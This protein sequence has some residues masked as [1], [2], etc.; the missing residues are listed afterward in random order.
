MDV[1]ASV[2]A[3]GRRLLGSLLSIS[4]LR[5]ASL[6]FIQLLGRPSLIPNLQFHKPHPELTSPTPFSRQ[7]SD[8]VCA[9]FN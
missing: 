6:V 1:N 7:P 2:F 9:I 4:E 3:G 5:L 8:P